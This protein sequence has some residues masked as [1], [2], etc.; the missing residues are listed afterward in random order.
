[1]TCKDQPFKFDLAC[2]QAFKELKRQ[3]VSALV[4]AHF[5]LQLPLQVETDA[6]DKVVSSAFSQKHLDSKW[7]LVAFFLKT[8]EDVELNYLIYNKEI[9]AII[10][11]F[12]H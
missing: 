8:I 6:L 3:L 2:E 10:L 11:S 12:Q 7:H 4:L 1:L 9:L 5:D